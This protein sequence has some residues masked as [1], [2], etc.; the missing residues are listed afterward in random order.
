MYA[1][2]YYGFKKVLPSSE[3]D[4]ILNQIKQ[5]GDYKTILD[6]GCGGGRFLVNAMDKGYKLTGVDFGDELIGHLQEA[7]PEAKFQEINTFYEQSECYDVI[8]VSNVFEH[9]T[10]PVEVLHKL[11]QRLHPNGILVV[12]GPIEN[13]FTLAGAFR[14]TLFGLRKKMG[15]VVSHIPRHIIYANAEN[16]RQFFELSGL[17]TISYKLKETPWPFPSKWDQSSTIKLKIFFFMAKISSL[18]G[19][20]IPKSGN[21]FYYI[22]RKNKA[23][24]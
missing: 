16:Q 14:K 10:N 20:L 24:F 6:F 4:S 19:F 23:I 17:K 15:K 11:T 21:V 9:L 13:N 5:H 8:F 3:Y 18:L 1:M 12:D 7:Y 22:G 2:D